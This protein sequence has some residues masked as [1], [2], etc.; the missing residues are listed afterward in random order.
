MLIMFCLILHVC[1][2]ENPAVARFCMMP[3]KRKRP[4]V[5][6]HPEEVVSPLLEVAR[7]N[8]TDPWRFC[9]CCG[10]PLAEEAR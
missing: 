1:D 10:F 7:P 5:E 4:R 2:F 9:P 6:Q 8:E 3:A